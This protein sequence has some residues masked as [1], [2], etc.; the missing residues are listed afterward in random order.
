[1]SFEE[2]TVGDCRLILGDCREVLPTLE[3]VQA[4]VT[5]PPYGVAFTGKKTHHNSAA[6]L[7]RL[8]PYASYEDTEAN[9]FGT[10]LPVIQLCIARFTTAAFFMADTRIFDMPRNGNLG[11]I[12]LPNGCGMGRWGFQ[13]FMHVCLYGRCPYNATGQGARPNGK[14]GVSGTNESNRVSH[15]CAK[16]LDVMLWLV[17]RTTLP[18]AR[19]LDPFAGA[20]TTGV[21]C[22]RLGRP[23]IGIEI[24]RRY[25]DVGCARLEAATAALEVPA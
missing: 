12:F 4:V 13:T 5:D 2:H 9:W 18:G 1:M 14:Y 21:A 17:E 24:E 10:I 22:L 25:F 20:F 7:K 23:F 16:P 3:D 8:A 11:G 6:T 15:P 19:V